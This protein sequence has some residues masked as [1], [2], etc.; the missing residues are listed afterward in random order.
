DDRVEWRAQL[1]GHVGEKFRLVPVGRLDLTALLLDLA[2][3]PGVLNGQYGL[4]SK[5]FHKLDYF[6]TELAGRLSPYHQGAHDALLAQQR[7]NQTRAKTKPR[8]NLTH[9]RRITVLFGNIG[10]LNRLTVECGAPDHA[11]S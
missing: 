8:Q 7:N 10:N 5:S 4:S 9:A 1:M 11:V 6:G 2:K 3:Q